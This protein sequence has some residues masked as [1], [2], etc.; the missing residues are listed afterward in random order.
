MKI[1]VLTTQ[2]FHH[3]YFIRK[4]SGLFKD[5]TVFQENKRLIF[6]FETSHDFEIERDDFE[7]NL[8]FKESSSEIKK[9]VNTEEF[10]DLNDEKHVSRLKKLF[11]DL[12]IV[13]GTGVLRKKIL[14]T[15]N[16]PLLN[17]HGG[18]P[19]KYRGLDS[20]LWSI[21]H[22]DY[23]SLVV[24]LHH[25][26]SELDTGDIVLQSKV[27][28]LPGM[29]LKELRSENTNIC[30]DLVINTINSYAKTGK[31]NRIKQGQK[32]RYYSAMPTVLKDI[33]L[34]NFENYTRR[35]SNGK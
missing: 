31:L 10:E 2:T 11:P 28:I 8:W 13:F 33:C 30:S 25:V 15:I 26:N 29:K 21:Y 14:E 17:L 12:I 24:T 22:K 23:D 5:I 4:I 34:K 27:E 20:H 7:Q 16:C 18:D 1:L 32:G 6:P 35:L 9:I 3:A 19:E